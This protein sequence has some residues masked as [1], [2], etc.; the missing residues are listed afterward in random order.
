MAPVK[1]VVLPWSSAPLA[2]F[3]SALLSTPFFFFFRWF[4]SLLALEGPKGTAHVS[5]CNVRKTQRNRGFEYKKLRYFEED[6]WRDTEFSQSKNFLRTGFFL[7]NAR[8]K[9]TYQIHEVN[10]IRCYL[11]DMTH[12]AWYLRSVSLSLSLAVSVCSNGS[13]DL[14]EQRKTTGSIDFHLFKL[15][16]L[17]QG[18][19]EQQNTW[20]KKNTWAASIAYK[21]NRRRQKNNSHQ[22]VGMALDIK[23]RN[24]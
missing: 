7:L 2:I 20:T 22:T 14:N 18:S 3:F 17:S 6:F 11:C 5:L 12:H 19:K 10:L 24:T 16:F 1:H 8:Y 15:L 21:M 23:K 13:S 4:D 9:Y